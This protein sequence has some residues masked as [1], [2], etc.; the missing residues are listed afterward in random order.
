MQEVPK[1]FIFSP[2][3]FLVSLLQDLIVGVPGPADY[4]YHFL[5]EIR[6]P[7]FVDQPVP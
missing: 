4:F 2:S 7:S 3:P 5:G 6:G 1:Q